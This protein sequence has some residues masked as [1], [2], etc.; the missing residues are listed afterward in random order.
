MS[1]YPRQGCLRLR[2][3]SQAFL[4]ELSDGFGAGGEAIGPSVV[5]DLGDE[6][7]GHG[8]SDPFRLL[9]FFDHASIM[10]DAPTPVNAPPAPD[11]PPTPLAFLWARC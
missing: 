1:F 8:D 4:D 11:V 3:F 7:G 10:R 6:F 9:A 2:L 5:V